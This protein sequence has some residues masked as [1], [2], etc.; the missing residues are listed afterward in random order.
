MTTY[1]IMQGARLGRDE[2]AGN[3]PH[4]VNFHSKWAEIRGQENTA[5][6]PVRTISAIETSIRAVKT[7]NL[8][9]PCSAVVC[10]AATFCIAEIPR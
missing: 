10:L 4:W 1:K 2:E 6:Q 3:R 9:I 5:D 7:E 8:A